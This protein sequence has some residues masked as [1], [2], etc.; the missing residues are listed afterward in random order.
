VGEQL[1]E[2][3]RFW[4]ELNDSKPEINE[5]NMPLKPIS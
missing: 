3:I 2:F 5:T 4:G 1:Q